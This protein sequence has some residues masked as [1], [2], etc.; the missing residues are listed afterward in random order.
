VNRRTSTSSD[1]GPDVAAPCRVSAIWKDPNADPP[2]RGP[3]S[4]SVGPMIVWLNGTHGAVGPR[5]VRSAMM[6]VQAQV[7]R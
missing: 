7:P 4:A 1:S 2:A 6:E 5:V 3:Q